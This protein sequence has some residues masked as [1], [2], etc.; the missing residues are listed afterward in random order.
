MQGLFGILKSIVGGRIG[1][2]T[3]MG[4]Q[5]RRQRYGQ[6]ISRARKLGANAIVGSRYYGSDARGGAWLRHRRGTGAAGGQVSGLPFLS[7]GG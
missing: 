4:E 6:V 7:S 1:A 5:A 2:D 3:K